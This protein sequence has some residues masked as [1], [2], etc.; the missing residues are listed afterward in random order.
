MYTREN[1]RA[2]I[3]FGFTSEWLKKSRENF[4][5]I[6]GWS[7]AKPKQFANYLR[8]SIENR[9]IAFLLP[10]YVIFESLVE[11]FKN[12]ASK[13]ELIDKHNAIIKPGAHEWSNSIIGIAD[14]NVQYFIF[15]QWFLNESRQIFKFVKI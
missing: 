3:G 13:R 15:A 12:N 7:N 10:V 4:E 5:P 8:H 6:T 14:F 9:S 1:A 11:A 2:M